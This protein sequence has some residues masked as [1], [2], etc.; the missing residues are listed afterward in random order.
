MAKI[1]TR[2]RGIVMETW[3]LIYLLVCI[4]LYTI[5]G[6]A[7]FGGGVLE[8]SMKTKPHLQKKLQNTLA[9][10]WEANHV[11]LIAV[12]V[13]LFVGMPKAYVALMTQSFY[14]IYLVLLGIVLRGSFFTLRKYDPTPDDFLTLYHALFRFSSILPPI[15]FA[16]IVANMISTHAIRENIVEHMMF[17]GMLAI[18]M[19]ILFTYLAS[20]LFIGELKQ[21]VDRD[22]LTSKIYLFFIGTFFSGALVLVWGHLSGRVSL[23]HALHPV[24]IIIQ[25]IATLCTY[26]VWKALQIQKD[27]LVRLIAGIQVSAIL[28]GWFIA[29]YPVVIHHAN[30]SILLNEVFAPSHILRDMN[31]LFTIA[32]CLILPS[33]VYLFK[34]FHSSNEV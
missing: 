21:T 19:I 8:W 3:T 30:G 34:V 14:P 17:Q 25:C 23:V 12:I 32:L 24:Q 26:G 29:Q 4:S 2:V 18:F 15:G 11:W 1:S 28:C 9:P 7:D 20:V 10:I 31:I 6:G 13:I 22:Y 5:F 27:W 33:L 16:M